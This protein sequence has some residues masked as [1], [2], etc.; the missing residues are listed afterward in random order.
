MTYPFY[1]SSFLEEPPQIPVELPPSF[2]TIQ[3][4]P[5]N[6]LPDEGLVDAVNV[7][8]LLNQPLLLTGEPGTGK[9][10]LAYHLAYQL[11][12][13]EPLKFD[14]KSTS[15]ARDLFYGYDALG[16]FHAA[17]SVQLGEKLG[18]K[19]S[20]NRS[21][22]YLIYNALGLAIVLTNPPN[23]IKAFLPSDMIPHSK[24]QRS[25]VLIDE[26]DKAPRD[27]PNDILSEIEQMYFRIPEIGNVKIEANMKMRPIV[28]MNS[29]SE[30]PLPDAFLRRCVYYNIP[31]PNKKRLTEI[32]EARLGEEVKHT[33]DFLSDAL[34]LFLVLRSKGGLRKKPATA[35]LLNWLF[36]L[37]G[38]FEEEKVKNP[39]ATHPEEVLR[40]LSSLVK[41][42]ED[43][44]AAQRI[45]QAWLENRK[46]S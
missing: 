20:N 9:T 41:T 8:L 18:E 2:Y 29:N 34:D 10:Q 36:V 39:L 40:T 17:Q 24:P 6:Y 22:D 25:V 37:R 14:T 15:T 31:F 43:Q 28:V 30:K 4:N 23:E 21:V 35:E 13:G 46:S 42:L 38:M 44:T 33:S 3:T 16:R 45:V 5:K 11:G 32:V 26:L 27:F 12:L 7:A 19:I 1:S